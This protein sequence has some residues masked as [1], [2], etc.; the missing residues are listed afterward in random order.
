MANEFMFDIGFF[1]FFFVVGGIVGA[2][3]FKNTANIFWI[4]GL[5]V[6]IVVTGIRKLFVAMIQ[7]Y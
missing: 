2:T 5:V 4:A 3:L 6:G 7:P 1:V